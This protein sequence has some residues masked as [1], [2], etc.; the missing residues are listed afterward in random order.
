MS[1]ESTLTLIESNVQSNMALVRPE[2]LAY[3]NQHG[4][5]LARQISERGYGIIPTQSGAVKMSREDLEAVYST[6]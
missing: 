4:D 1:I 2:V 3:L 6:K 5:D